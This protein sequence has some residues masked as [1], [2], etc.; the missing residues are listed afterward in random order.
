M[1][2]SISLD[3]LWTPLPTQAAF[4]E[5]IKTAPPLTIP[6]YVGAYG[7][8][9]TS[10]VCRAT[11]GLALAHPGI[12]IL[13][14]RFNFTE[15]RDTTLAT[16]FDLIRVVENDVRDRLPPSRRSEFPGIGTYQRGVGDYHVFNQS[17]IMFRHLEDGHRRFKS[18]EI[19]A[20]GVDE[21]SEVEADQ[22]EPQTIMTLQARLRQKGAPLVGYMVS[23]PTGFDHWLYRWYGEGVRERYGVGAKGWPI[24]R[25]NT[26]ENK[27]HLPATYEAELRKN[28]PTSWIKRYLEGEW[29]GIDEGAPVF[30]DFDRA[31]HVRSLE[32]HKR[33]PVHVGIDLGYNA[34]GVVWAQVD[35]VSER[36]HVLYS[37]DPK[38][39]NVYKLA[40]GIQERN[41]AWF[42]H[43]TF[44]YYAGH[45]A[46]ARKDT[47]DKTSA[48]IL[49]EYGMA[50]HVRM[51]AIERGFSVIRSLL[52]RRD[53]GTPGI[54]FDPRNTI[55]IEAFEGGYRYDPKK[56]DTPEKKG[57]YDQLVDAARYIA[58]NLFTTAG[59]L[60]HFTTRPAFRGL[61]TRTGAR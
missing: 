31:L 30:P 8:G 14:G 13:L 48:Q 41:A 1:N 7:S 61:A 34:P 38:N 15:L 22:P 32:W 10:V 9:K 11:L 12:R 45:D 37:W 39:L 53:D 55:L 36:L 54:W 46:N 59:T 28:Y 27:G 50:P 25:T 5:A 52:R 60:P 23:N 47:N 49:S 29:G 26:L 58:V 17:T 24:F 51:T 3:D 56:E 40:E 19:G 35:P 44:E 42:P 21:A 2:L 4:L 18:L 33:R 57:R 6:A 20:F 16:F 43:A